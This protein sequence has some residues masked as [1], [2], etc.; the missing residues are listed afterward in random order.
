MFPALP[1][2]DLTYKRRRNAIFLCQR[3]TRNARL[4]QLQHLAHLR[5]GQLRAGMTFASRMGRRR[6]L[7]EPPMTAVAELKP[8]CSVARKAIVPGA[9][10]FSRQTGASAPLAAA[11]T[12][13][14]AVHPIMDSVVLGGTS[15]R[16]GEPKLCHEAQPLLLCCQA[17]QICPPLSSTN[18]SWRPSFMVAT[19]R[20]TVSSGGLGIAGMRRRSL[21]GGC[22]RCSD[23]SS[24]RLSGSSRRDSAGRS[25]I[26]G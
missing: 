15:H 4:A 24:S 2:A 11:G 9:C 19:A 18:T 13:M 22:R 26:R 5:L 14:L 10:V 1:T 6:S 12:R 25:R 20:A 8:V 21:G 16:P 3:N 17:C 7:I 23:G